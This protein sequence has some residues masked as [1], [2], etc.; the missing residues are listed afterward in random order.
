MPNERCKV[1]DVDNVVS[2]IEY[3]W[4]EIT[5]AVDEVQADIIR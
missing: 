4:K 3:F 1:T 5:H 2:V